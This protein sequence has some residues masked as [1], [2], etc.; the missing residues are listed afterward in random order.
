MKFHLISLGCPKNTVDSEKLIADLI[1]KGYSYSQEINKSDFVLI[2]T[3]GFIRDAK[4]ESLEKIMKVVELKKD[5]PEMKVI[6][7]GCLIK[8]YFDTIQTEIPE[9]DHIFTFFTGSE[10]DT[11]LKPQ[12]QKHSCSPKRRYLT[13]PHVGFL[14]IAEG[15]DNRCAYCAIPDIRGPFKSFSIDNLI[16]EAQELADT[17]ARELIV[18]AQ[19]TTNYGR[20]N[21]AKYLLPELLKEI[22]TISRIKW[23]RLQY[24][25]PKRLTPAIIDELFSIP[26]VLQYFDI[27]F[28][29]V[30]E[31]ILTLMNRGVTKKQ[32]TQ[33]VSHIR[34]NYPAGTLRTTLIVG[35]P[36][37]TR[38]DFEELINYI[39]R[40]PFDRLGAFPYSPEEGTPAYKISPKV[41]NPTRKNRLDELM[42]LQ[43]LIANEINQKMVGKKYEVIV[44]RIENDQV[45]GR[46][47]GDSPEIDLET[48]FPHDGELLPGDFCTVRITKADSYDLYAEKEE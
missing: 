41:P 17:G 15:C 38:A 19:D 1:S 20:D 26:K 7:F 16:K 35:F 34:K 45:F 32:L 27:P 30:S 8:R 5:N 14:K 18:V 42:T 12:K 4:E 36:G 31:R 23:I 39:E 21:N 43:G 25:H 28:Q 13:L 37:E 9:I 3:C 48:S 44:D 40:K 46:T 47:H 22:S 6:V 11:I 33:I 24:L 2:N 29:H 10:L